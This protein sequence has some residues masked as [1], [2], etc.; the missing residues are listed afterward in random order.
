VGETKGED[1][2]R[3]GEKRRCSSGKEGRGEE[4]RKQKKRGKG[5]NPAWRVS[6]ERGR[7]GEEVTVWERTVE[8][9]KK[10]GPDFTGKDRTRSMGISIRRKERK[11]G[12]GGE[13]GGRKKKAT[14]R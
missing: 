4:K 12:R 8:I 11:K 6:V 1:P 7:G 2:G 5:K 14:G 13:R 9:Q 10:E 3:H